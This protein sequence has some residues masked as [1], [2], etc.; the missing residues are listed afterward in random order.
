MT[1]LTVEIRR[2]MNEIIDEKLKN[3]NPP[4]EKNA[5][6][7]HTMTLDISIYTSQINRKK[8]AAKLVRSKQVNK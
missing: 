2:K 7:R 4:K 8:F 6:A 1:S 5:N 3:S